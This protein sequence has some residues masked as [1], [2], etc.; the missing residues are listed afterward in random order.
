MNGENFA[1]KVENLEKNK[2]NK[3][4]NEGANKTTN[5]QLHHNLQYAYLK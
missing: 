4:Q 2:L 5:S 1:V 3:D